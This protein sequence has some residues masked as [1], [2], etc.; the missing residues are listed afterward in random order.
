MTKVV[1]R[2]SV[3]LQRVGYYSGGW[4]TLDIGGA[5]EPVGPGSAGLSFF[6]IAGWFVCREVCGGRLLGTLDIG[7]GKEPVGPGKPVFPT[8]VS[9]KWKQER[10]ENV[11]KK[12]NWG[13]M[14]IRRKFTGRKRARTEGA[15]WLSEKS[16]V[17][18]NM[19]SSFVGK[20][21]EEW[22]GRW[23]IYKEEVD[24]PQLKKFGFLAP[25]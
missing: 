21:G 3:C 2:H 4:W 1:V 14:M 20:E 8:R 10:G 19:W 6:F 24:A 5:E 9:Q 25:H 17:Q 18:I 15:E 12:W 23:L 7:G 11:D 16:D 22:G 13:L